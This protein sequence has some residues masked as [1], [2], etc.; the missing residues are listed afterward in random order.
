MDAPCR[1][2][3]ARTF[4]FEWRG[5][6]DVNTTTGFTCLDAER[7]GPLKLAA[8]RADCVCVCKKIRREK[9]KKEKKPFYFKSENQRGYLTDFPF[10][11]LI[12]L[13]NQRNQRFVSSLGSVCARLHTLLLFFPL[14][15]H[16]SSV[17][18]LSFFLSSCPVLAALPPVARGGRERRN[19]SRSQSQTGCRTR[20]LAKRRIVK[21]ASSGRSVSDGL[22]TGD[23]RRIRSTLDFK[24]ERRPIPS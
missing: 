13:M 4:V 10:V 19:K 7:R 3:P 17:L 12:V 6:V 2:E 16:V 5:C 15:C 24:T 21:S 1:G 18:S 9:K 11:L 14:L 22:F 8:S 20:A 23:Q